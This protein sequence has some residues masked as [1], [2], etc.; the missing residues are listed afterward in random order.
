MDITDIREMLFILCRNS[1]NGTYI[2]FK[3]NFKNISKIDLE[4]VYNEVIKDNFLKEYLAQL[5]IDLDYL[6]SIKTRHFEMKMKRNGKFIRNSICNKE[7]LK[8]NH[9][10]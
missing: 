6:K 4:N 10:Y 1:Y 5:E 3:K 2:S 7:F 8:T 9:I